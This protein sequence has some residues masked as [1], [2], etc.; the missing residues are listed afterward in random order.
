MES[1][2]MVFPSRVLSLTLGGLSASLTLASRGSPYTQKQAVA[3][4]SAQVCTLGLE[5]C[6]N[7]HGILHIFSL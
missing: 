7:G 1:A 5:P 2:V 3:Q 4:G 6:Y